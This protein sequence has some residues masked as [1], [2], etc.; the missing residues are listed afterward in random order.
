MED[1]QDIQEFPDISN[2]T[3]MKHNKHKGTI[4]N[5]WKTYRYINIKNKTN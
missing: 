3:L 4:M 2:M 1:I 5:V